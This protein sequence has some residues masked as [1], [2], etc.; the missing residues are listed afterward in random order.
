MD[1]EV[2]TKEINELSQTY[3]AI[4]RRLAEFVVG[5]MQLIDLIMIAML[6][7]GHILIEGVPG[8]AKT[9]MAKSMAAIAG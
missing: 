4:N 6:A 8:T 3:R 7:E 1:P 2:L 9:T 5:N